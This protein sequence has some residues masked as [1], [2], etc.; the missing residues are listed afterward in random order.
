MQSDSCRPDRTHC[1]S[2][3]AHVPFR[4]LLTT[5]IAAAV[6]TGLFTLP[7]V[8]SKDCAAEDTIEKELVV[9]VI[10]SVSIAATETG[11]ISE[12][13]VREGTQVTQGQRIGNLDDRKAKLEQQLAATQW[14]MAT[15]QASNRLDADLAEK[16]LA[17][18]R[19]LA[20]QH[21]VALEIAKKKSEN[22]ARVLASQKAE[23]V[24]ENELARANEARRVFIDSVSESEIDGLQ[25]ALDR[26]RLET[27]QA[28]FEREI[29]RLNLKSESQA[30]V[31]HHLNVEQS[32]ISVE[33]AKVT[34]QV[35]TLQSEFQKQ[36]TEL[37]EL[38]VQRHRIVSPLNG[39]VVERMRRPG[40]W[41]KP[42]DAIVRVVRLDRLR[43]EG[44]ADATQIQKLKN[45]RSVTLIARQD[46]TTKT[47][48]GTIVFIS[49]EIDPVNNEVRF[50][51]EFDN[52]NLDFLP[53]MRVQLSWESR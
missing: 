53:G 6:A 5:R 44:F 9:V 24:A 42:G 4:Q 51:V 22:D 39:F 16:K 35:Q 20:K 41:V 12:L 2:R 8:F 49:P 30:A 14:K 40:D 29:D 19:Q 10:D 36:Q 32:Q 17:H 11:V 15:A 52:P 46:G 33:Q 7:A 45:N 43:A 50:W 47:R 34:E 37:A 25:L 21:E 1:R 3:L 27:R 38:A 26:T 48:A 31:A 23:G 13:S 18:Q 28:Q